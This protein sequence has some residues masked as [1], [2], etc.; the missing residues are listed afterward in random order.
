M[1]APLS[2]AG[3]VK[4][5]EDTDAMAVAKDDDG[6]VDTTCTLGAETFVANDEGSPTTLCS[7]QVRV[8]ARSKLIA[9]LF[10]LEICCNLT[11][12]VRRSA[13]SGL[14]VEPPPAKSS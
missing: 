8:K 12:L 4:N 7:E 13:P 11:R 6:G 10:A 2:N 1:P 14:T 5:C 9:S 3:C